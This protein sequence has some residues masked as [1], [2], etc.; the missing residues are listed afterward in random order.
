[1]TDSDFNEGYGIGTDAANNFMRHWTL[2]GPPIPWP[3]ANFRIEFFLNVSMPIMLKLFEE[4]CKEDA[5]SQ[6]Y[7]ADDIYIPPGVM[8]GVEAGLR[9]QLSTLLQQKILR[10]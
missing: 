6:G 4:N 9:A 3:T 10:G 8:R 2:N 1:M 7:S 5:R